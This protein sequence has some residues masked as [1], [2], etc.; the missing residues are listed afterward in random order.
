[1]S[2]CRNK[3]SIQF[4]NRKLLFHNRLAPTR[5]VSTNAIVKTLNILKIHSL[6]NLIEF[7]L[8]R[9]ICHLNRDIEQMI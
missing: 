1:M 8:K 2:K 3:F 4:S 6:L 9:M 5:N 7:N